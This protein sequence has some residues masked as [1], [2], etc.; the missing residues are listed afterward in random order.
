VE[1]IPGLMRLELLIIASIF[2]SLSEKFFVIKLK[3]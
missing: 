3:F 2:F 1:I